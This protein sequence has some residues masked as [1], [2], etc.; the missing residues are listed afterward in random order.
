MVA[1]NKMTKWLRL[2]GGGSTK[3][4][5]LEQKKKQSVGFRER[6]VELCFHRS[7]SDNLIQFSLSRDLPET[8]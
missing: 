3:T 4:F 6:E 8:I 2:L 1:F 7:H 5:N